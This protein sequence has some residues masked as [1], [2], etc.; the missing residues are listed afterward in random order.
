M[1]KIKIYIFMGLMAVVSITSCK[2]FMDINENPN[3][4]TEGTPELVL[5]QSIVRTAS[6]MVNLNNFGSRLIGYQANA[7]GYGGWGDVVSYNYTTGSW[8]SIFESIYKANEDLQIVKD[9]S[10]ID[11]AHNAFIAAALVLQSYNYQTLVDVYNDVPYTEALTGAKALQ[12]KYDKA[13]DIY[14]ALADSIDVAL[15]MLDATATTTAFKNADPLF[16]GNITSWKQFANTV[17]LRLVLR[18]NGKVSFT[19]TSF[20]PAGFLAAD[21]LVNPGYSKID[22]KQNPMWSSWAYSASGS[23]VSVAYIPTPYVL[24]FYDG[25][26]IVD[27]VRAKLV[28]RGGLGVATNQL[29]YQGDD[30]KKG[31]TPSAW[32]L[33]A[34]TATSYGVG[35]LKG[36][37]M[38]QPIMLA[39][40]SYFL[41]AQA[42]LKGITGTAADAKTNFEKGILESFRYLEKTNTGAI[43]SGY[44][45][46]DD[47]DAYVLANAGNRLVDFDL[48]TTDEQKV[49]AIVTQEYIAMNMVSGH[50]AWFEFLRTGYPANT[51]ANSTANK[52]NTFVSFTSEATSPN[53]LPA[54]ILYPASEYKYNAGNIPAG[55]NAF[56]SKIFWA[57]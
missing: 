23:S 6:L 35:L 40:E 36:P 14:K 51:G 8:A 1:K 7:G 50:Q 45:P 31:P 52:Q 38:G 26:K 25:S 53:K 18:A 24:S 46:Q 12:P 10:R 37:D 11:D 32:I 54:R 4:A 19:N 34:N 21:A 17:K 9:L 57:K 28:F 22:G 43:G 16:K 15:G 56:T 42:N 41:Q 3:S 5:P 48:A 47:Y 49:E 2:K 55:I 13:E 44:V 29:G 33:A 20:N 27:D 30:A 39:S